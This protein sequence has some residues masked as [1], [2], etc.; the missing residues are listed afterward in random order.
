MYSERYFQEA[1]V[2]A[3]SAKGSTSPNPAVGSVIVNNGVVVGT[4]VTQ[5]A[6]SEHAEIMALN[7]AGDKAR[8]GVMY[9]TLEPCVDYPGKR[10]PSC[11]QA[12][13]AAG[14]TEIYIG[15][16][17]PNPR[18]QGRGVEQLE[19]SGIQVH[20]IQDPDPQLLL[21]NE[22]YEKYIRT[23]LPFV[24][25]K[26][27]MTL[28]GNIANRKGD[29]QWI[30]GPSSLKWVHELRNRVDAIMV[31]IGTVLH[32]N[33]RLNVRLVPRIKDPLRVIIDPRGETPLDAHVL[34]DGGKTLFVTGPDIPDTFRSAC[35]QHQQ[36]ILSRELPV[37]FR[38][39]LYTLGDQ[40]QIES[41]FI[42][43]GGRVFYRCLQEDV[44]DKL[45]VC[46]AP[47]IL[48]GRGIQPFEGVTDRLMNDALTL[49]RISVENSDGD[50]IIQGYLHEQES[51]P[52][53]IL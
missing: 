17:D 21:L 14:I 19:K 11:S 4:G 51:G 9:V 8:G 2:L 29:S 41:L 15:M 23:R 18:V 32:D 1:V 16:L 40:F 45:I 48:G 10:T 27:A 53:K 47:K 5:A 46:V 37:S 3:R 31:G 43:G 35:R 6:G 26:Y 12:I 33:P 30:S 49:K 39:L 42:E 44:I 25:A 34:T 50:L 13:I 24:Y 20:L 28:D 52:E 7:Q 36:Q 22:D 38:E